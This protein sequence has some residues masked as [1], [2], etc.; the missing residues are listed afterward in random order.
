MCRLHYSGKVTKNS[1]LHLGVFLAGRLEG[2]MQFGPSLDK[3]RM[4]GLVRGTKWNGFLELNRMA[5]SEA[6]PRNSESRALGVALRM[7]RAHYPHVEWVV[8]FADGTQCGD[9]TIYR[10]AGFVLTSIKKNTTIWSAPDGERFT[11]V[12]LKTQPN[13]VGKIINRTTTTK[14][15]AIMNR[16]VATDTRR[17]EAGRL[18]AAIDQQPN[19]AASMRQF[20]AAGFAPLPGFQLRYIYFLT[21]EARARLTVPELPFSKIAEIGAAM[22]RGQAR[23]K[24][25]AAGDHPALGGET[26]TPALQTKPPPK[27]GG[28]A[29]VGMSAGRRA[30]LSRSAP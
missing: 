8:S 24:D 21:P 13:K 30:R 25:Q 26:P 4:L 15:K 5:F 12:G 18:L 3:R 14:R 20:K 19:G 23:G 28:V 10:A 29:L 9:G 17:P 22:Y 11:D 2:V 27:R 7:I 16:M 1:Q 6:L